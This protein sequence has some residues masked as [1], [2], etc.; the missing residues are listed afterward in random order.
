MAGAFFM[1]IS[2]VEMWGLEPQTLTLPV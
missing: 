1:P 2:L